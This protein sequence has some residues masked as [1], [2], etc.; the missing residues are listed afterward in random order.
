MVERLLFRSISAVISAANGRVRVNVSSAPDCRMKSTWMTAAP[1]SLGAS[2]RS[3][4]PIQAV[5]GAA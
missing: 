5:A 3:V 2:S 1:E 4:P